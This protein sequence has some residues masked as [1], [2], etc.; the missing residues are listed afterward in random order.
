M[1]EKYESLALVNLKEIAK[2]RGIKGTSTM[3]KSEVIEAMLAE[4]ERLKK[5]EER[6]HGVAQGTVPEQARFALGCLGDAFLAGLGLGGGAGSGV[7]CGVEVGAAAGGLRLLCVVGGFRHPTH[8]PP[9]SGWPFS[10]R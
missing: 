7:G 2:A 8:Q 4:D 10:R 1:R 5:E 3:K 6:L 9:L